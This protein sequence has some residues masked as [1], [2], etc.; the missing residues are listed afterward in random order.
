MVKRFNLNSEQFNDDFFFVHRFWFDRNICNAILSHIEACIHL[1]THSIC[2][3][4]EKS[5]IFFSDPENCISWKSFFFFYF[6]LISINC[7]SNNQADEIFFLSFLMLLCHNWITNFF[8][9]HSSFI[10]CII[11]I[12][13]RNQ[14]I[15][16]K[17]TK[18]IQITKT[19]NEQTKKE[20]NQPSQRE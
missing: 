2:Y 7:I 15:I 8:F 20:A 11:I 1:F 5:Y 14:A 18:E 17:V 9:L 10:L 13:A 3:N 16:S 6:A 4:P 19:I 12:I